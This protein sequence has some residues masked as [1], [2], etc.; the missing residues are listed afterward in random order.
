MRLLIGVGAAGAA[1]DQEWEQE[2]YGVVPLHLFDGAPAPPPLPV[3]EDDLVAVT[4]TSGTTG[5]P[6]LIRHTTASLAGQSAIQVLGGRA[7]L[8][9]HDVIATCLTTAHARTLSGLATIAAVGAPHLAMVDPDPAS[10]A[11]LLTRHRP[12]LV[13]TF[14]NV[15]LAW[16]RLAEHPGQPLA[17][18][19]IFLST[20]DAAHPRTIRRLLTASHRRFPIY[21]QAYAQSETG[22]IALSFRGRRVG[23]RGDARTVGWPALALSRVRLIDPRTGRRIGRPHRL[24]RIQVTGPGR[25]DGYLGETGRTGAGQQGRWWDT[26]DLGART[27]TGQLRLAGRA[28]DHLDALPD[29]LA[30]EDRLLDRLDELTELVLTADRHGRV[31]PVLCT[32]DDR[33]LD[34]ARWRAATAGLPPLA[35]PRQLRW[36]ELP[37]TATWKVRRPALRALLD[38]HPDAHPADADT[39]SLPNRTPAAADRADPGDGQ[40]S[41][42]RSGSPQHRP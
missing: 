6:K 7:L 28:V 10:A 17:N 8:R 9:R 40:S 12:T 5:P 15:F 1:G 22:A 33:P 3:G 23:V 30:L 27:W 34:L 21:A 42:D 31:V 19:R 25:F 38:P 32:Q 11:R 18:V 39:A 14:P 16:E 41:P 24:G 2:R 36:A 35:S 26:G 29:Y 37:T 13:E 4:H 20:F